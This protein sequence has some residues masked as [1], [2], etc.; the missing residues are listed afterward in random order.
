[1][2]TLLTCRMSQRVVRQEGCVLRHLISVPF[3]FTVSL[4]LDGPTDGATLL[5]EGTAQTNPAAAKTASEAVVA[6][7]PIQAHAPTLQWRKWLRQDQAARRE[8]RP[9]A[10]AGAVVQ[11]TAH[12]AQ[13]GW[14]LGFEGHRLEWLLLS[15]VKW[16]RTHVWTVYASPP[17][18]TGSDAGEAGF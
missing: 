9:D 18:G 17:G 13:V 14:S 12:E 6:V 7:R 3:G 1:M 11:K 4:D 8:R 16:L 5:N 10:R 2:Q 15:S